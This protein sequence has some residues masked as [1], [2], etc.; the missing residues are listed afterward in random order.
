MKPHNLASV[1]TTAMLLLPIA[2]AARVCPDIPKSWAYQ[3]VEEHQLSLEHGE[4]GVY[5]SD[6]IVVASQ[7]IYFSETWQEKEI[8]FFDSRDGDCVARSKQYY[9]GPLGIDDLK[10]VSTSYHDFRFSKDRKMLG[11]RTD[12][13][14]KNAQRILR[15]GYRVR[16]LYAATLEKSQK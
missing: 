7:T 3:T 13:M 12:Y 10:V 1:T 11:W 8:T 5:L 15:E 6:G 9:N 2:A 4:Y 14:Q 16:A